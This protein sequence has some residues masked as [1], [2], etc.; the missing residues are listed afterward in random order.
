MQNLDRL[1]DPNEGDPFLIM[2]CIPQSFPVNGH[3]T[4]M[5]PGQTFEYTLP[6]IFGRPWAQIWERYHE[7]G[8]ER[9][10]ERH[11]PVR[12]VIDGFGGASDDEPA[13]V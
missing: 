2:E 8:M 11:G 4:P 9:P 13:S 3:A 5:S 10:K 1:G 6:D 7:E 12:S